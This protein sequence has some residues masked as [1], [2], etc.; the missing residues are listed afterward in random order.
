MKRWMAPALLAAGLALGAGP[1]RA[2]A[3][4]GGTE[5]EDANGGGTGGGRHTRFDDDVRVKL[6]LGDRRGGSPVARIRLRNRGR[7]AEAGV[8]VELRAGS[9]SGALLGSWTADLARGGKEGFRL[10]VTPP[11]GTLLLV[12]TAA[13]DGIDDQYPEDNV[14]RAALGPAAGPANAALGSSLF[15]ANCASCHGTDAR[16]TPGAPGIRHVPAGEISEAVREGE[17]GMPVFPGLSRDDVLALAAFLA[18][19]EAAAPP[20]PPPLPPPPPGTPVTYAGRVKAILDAN[21]ASC[22]GGTS[23]TAGVRL[24]TYAGASTN[25]SR[26]LAAVQAGRMPPSGPLAA[27]DAQALADWVAAGAPR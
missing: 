19:P 6:T 3:E 24:N 1:F 14:S 26:A 7:N 4:D 9:E 27:A 20:P 13:L 17:G 22:H 15:A 16:G 12:A 18:D 5:S 11:A 10:R 21:C 8:V 25:A 2:I 23:P